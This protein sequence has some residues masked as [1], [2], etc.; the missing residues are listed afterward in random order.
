ME[1]VYISRYDRPGLL[2]ICHG[3]FPDDF[4]KE[5]EHRALYRKCFNELDGFHDATHFYRPSV[6]DEFTIMGRQVAGRI[7]SCLCLENLELSYLG[8]KSPGVRQ[9]VY[10]SALKGP[11]RIICAGASGLM[12][13]GYGILESLSR[14]LKGIV[15]DNPAL[16]LTLAPSDIG[17]DD[18]ATLIRKSLKHAFKGP[19]GTCETVQKNISDLEDAGIV[20][21]LSHDYDAIKRLPG[22]LADIS[23][24]S[25]RLSVMSKAAQIAGGVSSIADLMREAASSFKD[26]HAAEAGF[27]DFS[28]PDVGQAAAR[29]LDAGCTHI[30]ATGAP[31][32]MH[33]H[34][35]SIPGPSEAAVQLRQ[36]LQDTDMVYIE[37]DPASIAG[38][39]AN[40]IMARV[41]EA[42]EHGTSF[43]GMIREL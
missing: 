7:S 24:A 20:L 8:L 6:E 39:V 17:A 30:I 29:L 21:V 36:A 15:R 1:G 42:E 26:F 19:Q 12:M 2:L 11:G 13:P 10:R 27:I 4:F 25:S 14:E 34:P 31:S 43:K 23:G 9:A 40:I 37:P 28:L 22:A 3:D 35:Y 33:R 38:D 18:I 32:L 16:D 5:E 41:L